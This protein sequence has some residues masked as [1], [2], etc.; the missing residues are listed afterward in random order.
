MKQRSE[1]GVDES[2]LMT[3]WYKTGALPAINLAI[4]FWAGAKLQSPPKQFNPALWPVLESQ[5]L[6][7]RAGSY[8]AGYTCAI[9][10]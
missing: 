10:E 4:S 3:D 7:L 2:Y 5:P 8:V 6:H 9:A 1:T